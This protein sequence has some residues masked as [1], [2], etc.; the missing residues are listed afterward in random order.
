MIG[1][2]GKKQFLGMKFLI[3]RIYREESVA[4]AKSL[5]GSHA[6]VVDVDKIWV[7]SHTAGIEGS[8]YCKEFGIVHM[9]KVKIYCASLQ[10]EAVFYNASS[11]SPEVVVVGG[12][13]VS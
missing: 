3:R 4:A 9:G 7:V 8:C 10:M 11:H 1:G 2:P 6:P 12:R 5:P 13:A